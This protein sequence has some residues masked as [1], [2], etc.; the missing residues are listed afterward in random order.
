MHEANKVPLFQNSTLSILGL[1]LVLLTCLK[2]H[3]AANTLVNELLGLLC[4]IILPQPKNCPKTER[5]ATSILKSLGLS[6][7]IIHACPNGCALF[8]GPLE[9][10]LSCPMCGAHKYYRRGRSI[11]PH[12]VL[13][14]FPLIPKL[15]RMFGSPI[16]AKML[17]WH[18]DECVKDG[19]M[20]CAADSPMWAHVNNTWPHFVVDPQNLKLMLATNGIKH[21][22]QRSCTWSM[23]L[24]MVMILNLPPW[25]ATKKF[26]ILL[27]LIIYVPWHLQQ[28]ILMY[29]LL[30]FWTSCLNYGE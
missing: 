1:N 5:E 26:F 10:E 11:K 4:K 2:G 21:F 25:L 22:A 23:W 16:L 18:K 30:M 15:R 14:H 8:R 3:G 20:R 17:T 19:L 13:H 24:V 28:N 12:H 27:T 29:T 9:T 7:N 6:Y